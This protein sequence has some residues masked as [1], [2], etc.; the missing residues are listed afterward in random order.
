MTIARLLL[1]VA[2]LILIINN[3]PV[4]KKLFVKRIHK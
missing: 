1:I 3:Y 2:I 4:I